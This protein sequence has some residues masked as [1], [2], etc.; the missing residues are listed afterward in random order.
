MGIA[1]KNKEKKNHTVQG[2]PMSKSEFTQ[3]IKDS[4]ESGELDFNEGIKIIEDRLEG[5]RKIKK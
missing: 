1:K 2:K 3:F 5:Y 4:E